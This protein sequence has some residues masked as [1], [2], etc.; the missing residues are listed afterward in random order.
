MKPTLEFFPV[1]CLELKKLEPF[2]KSGKTHTRILSYDEVT[3]DWQIDHSLVIA[4]TSRYE[5]VP[6][7]SIILQMPNGEKLTV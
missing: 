1:E 4:I 6:K 2:D 3:K 7:F 5:T